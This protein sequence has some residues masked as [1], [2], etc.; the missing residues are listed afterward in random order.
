MGLPD[1]TCLL[2]ALLRLTLV[3]MNPLISILP[4]FLSNA[5]RNIFMLEQIRVNIGKLLDKCKH[6]LGIMF[7]TNAVHS[8]GLVLPPT[9]T[10]DHPLQGEIGCPSFLLHT[11]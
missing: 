10:D 2:A 1:S 9:I 7:I 4:L 5:I 3:L 6:M 8:V 11:C